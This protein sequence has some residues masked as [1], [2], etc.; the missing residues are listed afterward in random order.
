MKKTLVLLL[1]LWLVLALFVGCSAPTADYNNG[2]A[3]DSAPSEV[4]ELDKGGA[5]LEGA[6]DSNRK[7]IR[8]VYLTA[9]TEKYDTFL[10]ALKENVA[11]TG[12]YIESF[13]EY[14]SGRDLRTADVTLRIPAGQANR[15]LDL[16]A[17][18]TTVLRQEEKMTDVSLQYVDTE[19]HLKALRAEEESLLRLLETAETV[20]DIIALRDRLTDVRYQIEAY[21]STL[22]T[23]DN[24]VDYAIVTLSVSE[25]EKEIPPTQSLWEEMGTGFSE[26]LASLGEILRALLVLCV[27]LSPYFVVFAVLP[28]VAVFLAIFLPLRARKKRRKN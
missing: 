9:E 26:S 13:S 6:A 14:A 1:S 4:P 8:R 24:Q 17:S 11:A 23:F 27:T 25:V 5:D 19:A 10:A 2:A 28:G 18:A 22:R 12:G 7:L 16:I 20:S 3:V 21:E 15:L